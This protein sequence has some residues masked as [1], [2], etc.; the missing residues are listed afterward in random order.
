MSAVPA[1][2]N[3]LVTIVQPARRLV[4][5]DLRGLWDHRDLLF[6]LVRR[7]LRV[8]FAQT[9]AGGLWLVLQPLLQLAVY[10]F[11]FSRI[12]KSDIKVP[13][14]LFALAGLTAWLFIS[15]TLSTGAGSLVT[16][17]NVVKKVAK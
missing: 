17:S 6:F 12:A 10:A 13:Y 7:Q 5:L 14:P 4:P 16:N 15:R 2:P 11:V 8:R 9:K 3:P 1:S